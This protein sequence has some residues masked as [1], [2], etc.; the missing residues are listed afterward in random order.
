MPCFWVCQIGGATFVGVGNLGQAIVASTF[1]V[2]V[3]GNV[4]PVIAHSFTFGF[5]RVSRFHKLNSLRTGSQLTKM[6]VFFFF[7]RG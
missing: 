3:K 5:L 6:T 1:S 4:Y 2:V 7:I